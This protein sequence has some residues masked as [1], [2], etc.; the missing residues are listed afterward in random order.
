MFRSTCLCVVIVL[1][2]AQFVRAVELAHEP[3]EYPHVDWNTGP[4]IEG[5][6]GGAGWGGAWDDFITGEPTFGSASLA[7]GI[8]EFPADVSNFRTEPLQFV[9]QKGNILETSGNQART[10]FGSRSI[11]R[12]PLSGTFG[13]DGE[14]VW[15]S[16]LEQSFDGAGG[17][18]RWSGVS[19]GN[20]DFYLGKVGLGTGNYGLF[21][22]G[23]P[24]IDSGVSSK[25]QAFI[26]ARI[27]YQNGLDDIT[28][29][30][31]P[32]LA[33]TPTNATAALTH[34][35]ELNTFDSVVVAGRYSSDI[36]EIRLG[37]D[38]ASVAPF[39]TA[40]PRPEL[41]V[42]EPFDYPHVDWN[43]GP[44]IE[45]LD[46]GTG[47]GGAWDDFITGEPTF[48]DA[49]LATGI[50]E[51]PA[52]AADPAGPDGRTETLS[53]TDAQGN[54]LLTQEGNQLRT[55]FGSR[56]IARRDLEGT[57]GID[58]DTVWMSFLGQSFD[59][60]G[61][62][63]R[64]AGFSLGNGDFYLG[65]VGLDSGNW[66]LF[67]EGGPRIDSGVP[68]SE[69]AFIV[70]KI[71]YQ[72]GVDQ[73]TMWIDP[74]LGSEPDEA[75]AQIVYQAELD[76]FD[77]VVVAGRYSTDFDEFRLGTSFAAVA[78]IVPEP[79][80]AILIIGFA[81]SLAGTRSRKAR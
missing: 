57:Y 39:R 51:F 23:G 53:Y 44:G 52:D 30:V 69:Q 78:P 41:K 45:G 15:L 26:V 40:P 8:A 38:Y 76:R 68:S 58:G 12:R 47:W 73:I 33:E 28:L 55:S 17:S 54:V 48:V 49:T 65:K 79:S 46:G 5:L 13:N 29:W 3:F 34:S 72:E 60:A 43:S 21:P 36:D 80:S 1:F 64:W 7:T 75:T 16:F 24:R 19:L 56:S 70:A 66:G 32:V 22:R 27:D 25:E 37:T 42:Y 74:S 4:G 59:N 35:A 67:P 62:S 71:E 11:A 63:G 50:A 77:S 31:D 6:T 10:S 14:T 81:C 18:S 61:G 2:A 20:G 9:D